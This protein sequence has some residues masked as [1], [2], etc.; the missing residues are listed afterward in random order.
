MEREEEGEHLHGLAR[1]RS[2]W[3]EWE[4]ERAGRWFSGEEGSG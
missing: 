1:E 4:R 2:V 3:G